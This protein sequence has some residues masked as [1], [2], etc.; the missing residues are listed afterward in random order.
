MVSEESSDDG[1]EAARLLKK[2]NFPEVEKEKK[3]SEC[4][5]KISQCLQ[6]RIPKL[7]GVADKLGAM[8]SLSEPQK[9]SQA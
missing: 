4:C 1:E 3:P 6:K 5:I 8:K 7:E 9:A 2:L